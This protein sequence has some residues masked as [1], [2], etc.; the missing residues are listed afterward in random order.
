M[1]GKYVGDSVGT[2]DG[3]KVGEVDGNGVGTR[4]V[5]VGTK[6]GAAEGAAVGD[7]EG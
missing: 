6:V 4:V 5:Y 2:S 1:P 3:A 7:V